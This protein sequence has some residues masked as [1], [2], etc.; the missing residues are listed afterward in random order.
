MNRHGMA[1]VATLWLVV[2]L[3][4]VT[5]L[6]LGVVQRATWTSRNRIWQIRT[7]WGREACLAIL[8][9]REHGRSA[10]TAPEPVGLPSTD[11][12]QGLWCEATWEN[13]DQRLNLNTAT[14][15]IL[16]SLLTDPIRLDALLDWRDPDSLAR[17]SGAEA[18]WYRERGRKPPRNGP[19]GSVEELM[20][21]RGFD[22]STVTALASLLTVR[23]TGRLDLNTAP[24]RLIRLLPGIGEEVLS[25]IAHRRA[26]GRV[27]D[28]LSDLLAGL[29]P[30]ATVALLA[31]EG[32]LLEVATFGARQ[33]DLRLRAGVSGTP[34]VSESRLTV[35]PLDGRL[36]VIAVEAQ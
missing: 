16:S 18:V 33:R 28:G 2:A 5:A 29:S 17:P 36:A 24:L 22:S 19:F 4:G 1:L 32:A 12:G 15:A 3:T 11:L 23:G 27:I 25:N 7:G 13:P 21:V 34:F 10:N 20:Y 8:R 26:G 30:S 35:V 31:E 14:P 9:S 6:G